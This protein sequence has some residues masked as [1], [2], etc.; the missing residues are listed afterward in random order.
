MKNFFI[1]LIG[2][3]ILI[4]GVVWWSKSMQTS[5]PN[6]VAIKGLHSH[7][8]LAIYVKGEKQ[9][10]PDNIGIGG[11]YSSLPMG[12]S[13]IHTHDDANEGIIHL[14]FSGVVHKDDVTLGEFLKT[15][16]KD[17]N[18]FGSNVKMTVNGAENSELDKY[19]M[20][21]GDRIELRYE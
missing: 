21:D 5:D 17:I 8:I 9:S 4:G 2:L 7:P 19:V 3:L 1:T 6:V 16:G 13:P 12:M 20:G 11:Q 18:S 14:E 15:W 10:I